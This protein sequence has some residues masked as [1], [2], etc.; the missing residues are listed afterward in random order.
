MC[1]T[2]GSPRAIRPTRGLA[3]IPV[4]RR[5]E[6][7]G[8]VLIAS[9][10]VR[11]FSPLE[12]ERVEAMAD[13]LSVALANA[14]LFET[15]RQAEWRFR[16]LFR[17]APDAVLTVLQATGRI[18]EANDAVRAVFGLEPHQVIGRTLLELVVP[19][20]RPAA[21]RRRSRR[22]SPA[23]RRGWSCTWG[24]PAVRRASSR[25]RRAG[26]RKRIRRARCSS[27]AT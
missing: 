20:D 5:G 25:S 26:S 21:R 1:T 23:C 10:T 9:E 17:A 3:I 24:S 6:R 11:A 2:S 12:L 8:A 22:R 19:D 18:R 27:D 4:Q 14:E 16:T 13:L 7:I 15:M